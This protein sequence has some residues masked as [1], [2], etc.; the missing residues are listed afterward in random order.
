M[1]FRL[2]KG[3]QRIV[4][5]TDGINPPRY[6]NIDNIDS[7]QTMPGP[8]PLD[9]DKVK[10]IKTISVYPI[11][12]S[13]KVLNNGQLLAGSYNIGISFLDG[14]LNSTKVISVSNVI[15]IYHDKYSKDFKDIN[16][17]TNLQSSFTQYSN[18]SKSI[19]VTMGRL[20]DNFNYYR[21]YLIEASNG[22]GIINNVY[23]TEPI[24]IKTTTFELTGLNTPFKTTIEQIN[25]EPTIIATA[26]HIEQLEN[27]LI[28]ANILEL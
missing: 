13:I 5:F 6:I 26:K 7:F 2:R 14:D 3:N 24:P 4:Y 18:T 28:L 23:Y 9:P 8:Y 21:L 25:E 11:F 22:N 19:K 10:L 12:S 20:D 1:T 27:R 16:G 15:N 17:S